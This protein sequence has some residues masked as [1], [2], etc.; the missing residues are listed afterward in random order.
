[1]P[2]AQPRSL[3]A[4]PLLSETVDQEPADNGVYGS[5]DDAAEDIME[6][7]WLGDLRR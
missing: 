1:M 5:A 2:L 4:E 6:N 3:V 7:K